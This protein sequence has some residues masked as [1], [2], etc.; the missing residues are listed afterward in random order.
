MRYCRW[1]KSKKD[2][3]CFSPGRYKCNDCA[4]I[5]ERERE[6]ELAE[7][8]RVNGAKAQRAWRSRHP[9]YD[10]EYYQQNKEKGIARSVVNRA[11]RLGKI[12]RAST[13]N[14]AECGATAKHYHHPSYA[15][16]DRMN[17]VPLCDFCHKAVHG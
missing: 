5:R 1:C 9:S 14:C 13:L 4:I 2:D 10:N 7:W 12:P 15:R 8:R 17:V 16:E 11:V 6:A 3:S